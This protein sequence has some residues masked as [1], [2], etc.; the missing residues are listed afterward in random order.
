M[1]GKT[2]KF[3]ARQK[4]KPA[5]KKV[6]MEEEEVSE[7]EHERRVKMLKELGLVKD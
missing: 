3:P 6:E 1:G 2:L 7:E 5:E 4:Y